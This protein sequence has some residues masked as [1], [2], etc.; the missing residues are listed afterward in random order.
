MPSHQLTTA[1]MVPSHANR[2]MLT[3]LWRGYL[4]M[5]E[6]FVSS[7]CG[8]VGQL[9][10][11]FHLGK[12]DADASALA[13]NAGVDQDLCVSSYKEG[14]PEA[15]RRG[16]VNEATLNFATSNILRQKFAAGLF[17]RSWHVDSATVAAKLDTFRPL[18]LEASLRKHSRLANRDD[19][20]GES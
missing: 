16:Q 4:G 7:D 1:F 13:L 19:W 3:G 12:D 18:A 17:E 15:L 6:T 14:L 2:F 20:L 11:A 8:D 10:A 9:R 5:N